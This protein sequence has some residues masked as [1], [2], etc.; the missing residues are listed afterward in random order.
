VC[1]LANKSKNWRKGRPKIE[2]VAPQNMNHQP[3]EKWDRVDLHEGLVNYIIVEGI[4]G[5]SP[6]TWKQLL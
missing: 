5:R 1:E 6:D 3:K 4:S 2:A